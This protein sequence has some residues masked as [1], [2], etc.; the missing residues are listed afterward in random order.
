VQPGLWIERFVEAHGIRWRRAVGGHEGLTAGAGVANVVQ[1]T[2]SVGDATAAARL[3]VV[4]KCQVLP[5]RPEAQELSAALL[6][7]RLIP[8]KA[9]VDAAH[10]ATAT[11]HEMDFLL[12]W[13][14]RHIAHHH[15]GQADLH[16]RGLLRSVDL[17]PHELM[18]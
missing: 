13:N 16:P 9:Q 6:P 4:E 8:T 18:L 17:S 12:T 5:D 3:T 1:F 14:G 7:R 15:Y 11:V 2:R 10:L